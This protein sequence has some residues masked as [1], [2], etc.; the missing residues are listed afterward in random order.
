MAVMFGVLG[1][2]GIQSVQLFRYEDVL[3]LKLC[4]RSFLRETDLQ[5]NYSVIKMLPIHFVDQLF[6]LLYALF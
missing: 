1:L 2:S 5:N 4:L 3:H 6:D